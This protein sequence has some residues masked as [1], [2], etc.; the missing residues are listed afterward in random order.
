MR[1]IVQNTECRK[2]ELTSIHRTLSIRMPGNAWLRSVS[3][4]SN[5][6]RKQ[7]LGR[8]MPISVYRPSQRLCPLT[9]ASRTAG[10]RRD[11][12]ET[13]SVAR[14]NDVG[15]SS[16]HQDQQVTRQSPRRRQSCVETLR[17]CEIAYWI[18]VCGCVPC[19]RPPPLYRSRR[20]LRVGCG[21][22]RNECR[23]QRTGRD[24]NDEST[25][26]HA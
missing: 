4:V 1:R 21:C 10:D 9:A 15:A 11:D 19:F 8:D 2:A 23:Q 6:H 7:L 18:G 14:R 12:D 17:K 16:P 3:N 13:Q 20:V 5:T 26:E 25:V 22:R 24:D